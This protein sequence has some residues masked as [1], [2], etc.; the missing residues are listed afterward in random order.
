MF[1]PRVQRILEQSNLFVQNISKVKVLFQNQQGK[2]VN[3]I[4]DTL[5]ILK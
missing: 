3:Y 1:M 4:L 2:V 5:V